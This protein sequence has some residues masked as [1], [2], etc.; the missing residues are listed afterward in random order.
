MITGSFNFTQA[1]EEHNAENLII[2]PSKEL[3]QLYIANWKN[4]KEH[5]E[6]YKA[7]YYLPSRNLKNLI[8]KRMTEMAENKEKLK[9]ILDEIERIKV[10]M[11]RLEKEIERNHLEK[12]K[13]KEESERL[14]EESE[15]LI[16]ES[17]E[18]VNKP[19]S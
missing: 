4:H 8:T 18:L 5:S 14:K 3:A 15:K 19:H 13:L 10:E 6:V 12:E 16:N 7:R 11:E 1:V 17:D 2:I 9:K